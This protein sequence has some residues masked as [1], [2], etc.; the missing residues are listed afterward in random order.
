M[1]KAVNFRSSLGLSVLLHLMVVAMFV[2]SLPWFSKT[3]LD[4]IPTLTAEI[5]DIVPV[6]NLNEGLPGQTKDN[7]AKD[8]ADQQASDNTPT[9]AAAAPP[10][11][12]KPSPPPPKPDA[13]QPK[14]PEP[15][16]VPLPQDQPKD[17]AIAL[18]ITPDEDELPPPEP[19]TDPQQSNSAPSPVT[20]PKAKPKETRAAEAPPK[21]Q[22]KVNTDDIASYL[23]NDQNK[24]QSK[25]ELGLQVQ[26]L[27]EEAQSPP[28]SDDPDEKTKKTE[29]TDETKTN[30]NLA[31]LLDETV[32]D[33]VG[34]AINTNNTSDGPLGADIITLLKAAIQPCWNPP[35]AIEGA[36]A[37]IVDI[38]VDFNEDGEVIRVK[39]KDTFRYTTD[40]GFRLAAHAVE[41]AFKDCSPFIPPLPPEQFEKW[42]TLPFRFDPRG[43]L[44]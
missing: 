42:K 34:Q 43:F 31:D 12:P 10:P 11:P 13:Q 21:K 29:D 14:K 2:I 44:G 30:Q 8:N 32:R 28:K 41:R 23:L 36:N 17:N 26:N 16:D 33:N 19:E 39:F 20:P 6:T 1:L 9:A 7:S 3:P 4:A 40:E 18:N 25:N 5:V 38:I 37:L 15:V 24:E 22:P 35:S 27:I